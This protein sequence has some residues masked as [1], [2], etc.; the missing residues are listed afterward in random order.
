MMRSEMNEERLCP[1][2]ERFLEE[3]IVEVL[4]AEEDEKEL[5]EEI[6]LDLLV[7]LTL[8]CFEDR[9]E[10]PLE[11]YET[12]LSVVGVVPSK[13]MYSFFRDLLRCIDLDELASYIDHEV[14]EV[15]DLQEPFAER[16]AEEMLER[17]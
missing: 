1:V 3:Q 14:R 7:D 15:K 17:M 10:D 5:E 9:Y 16:L 12:F 11:Y 8:R 6:R 4:G 13:V 2:L